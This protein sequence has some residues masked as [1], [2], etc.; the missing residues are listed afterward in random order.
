MIDRDKHGPWA[1]VCGA[2][3]G[4]GEA[5]ARQL[6]AAGIGCVLVSRRQALLDELAA[7]I[8]ATGGAPCRA[9]AVDLTADDAADRL[10]AATAD[11]EIGLLAYNAGADTMAVKFHDRT[12]RQVLDQIMLNVVTLS[13]VVHRFGG[14]MRARKRGGILLVGSM[15]GLAGTGWVATYSATKAFD[16]ILAEGL[17]RELRVDNVDAM[18]LVAGATS[19]PAHHRMGARVTAE[20]PPMDPADVAREGLAALGSGPL[21]VAGDGNR[22]GFAA[23]SPAPREALIDQMTKGTQLLFD[24]AD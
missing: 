20:Y 2:S 17:W 22:A 10:D 6:C 13:K 11:L 23:M 16:Q 14:R 9:V 4:I 3:E 18:V 1:L 8:A 12:E 15:A 21:H 24:V 5:F 19:T 7:S